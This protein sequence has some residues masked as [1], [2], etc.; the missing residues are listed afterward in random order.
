MCRRERESKTANGLRGEPAV[1]S[2]ESNVPS[3][4]NPILDEPYQPL[5][6]DRIK[7]GSDAACGGPSST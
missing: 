7:E 4:V 2:G 3:I 6:A 1:V 5:W